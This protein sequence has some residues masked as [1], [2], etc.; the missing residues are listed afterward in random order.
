MAEVKRSR[1][2]GGHRQDPLRQTL[3]QLAQGGEPTGGVRPREDSD[4]QIYAALARSRTVFYTPAVL[5]TPKQIHVEIEHISSRVSICVDQHLVKIGKG[6]GPH[7]RL[8]K[9][10]ELLIIDESGLM[11]QLLTLGEGRPGRF[12]PSLHHRPAAARRTGKNTIRDSE[13][14]ASPGTGFAGD[15]SVH[16]PLLPGR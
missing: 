13:A 1:A 8:S 10:V 5:T 7:T 15:P 4:R 6:K 11:L 2:E 16:G 3:R 9:H 12:R 14:F